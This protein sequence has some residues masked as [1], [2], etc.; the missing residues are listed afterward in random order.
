[1]EFESLV[2]TVLA[3]SVT[4]AIISAAISHLFSERQK[5]N[6]YKRDYY[7]KIIDKRISAYEKLA[8]AIAVVGLKAIYPIND[9]EEEKYAFFESRQNFDRANNLLVGVLGEAHWLS[10][11]TFK[12]V[13]KLNNILA[14]I[15]DDEIRVIAKGEEWDYMDF[16]KAEEC[17]HKKIEASLLKIKQLA[18]QDRMKLHEVEKFFEEKK[19]EARK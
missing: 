16:F 6:D 18:V 7:K 8:A 2:G 4:S 10:P 3:S 1:M 19:E 17:S 5:E 14:G 11:R 12:E 15:L 9:T 13:Q